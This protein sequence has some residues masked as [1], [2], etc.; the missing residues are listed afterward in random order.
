MNKRKF[1][2][3]AALAFVLHGCATKPQPPVELKLSE[4]VS[5]TTRV[6]VAAPAL[7]KV[8]TFFPGA[9]CLLCIALAEGNHS[10]LTK[11]TQTLPPEG[12]DQLKEEIAQLLREQGATVT[13]VQEPLD[14]RKLPKASRKSEQTARLDFSSMKK[15][16]VDKLVVVNISALGMMRNYSAYVPNGV[17]RAILTGEG[18][19]VN[20]ADNTY[21][22]YKPID[23]GREAEG[24][25]DEPPSFPG[26]T[27]A[28]FQVLTEGRDAILEPFRPR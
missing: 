15:L 22:W 3:L 12:L 6:A 16:D 27:N 23:I 21:E 10:A 9:G 1:L 14:L 25:W 28:Y 24:G 8:N 18:Y 4:S 5:P 11:H 13:V 7:P 17:P 20:L 19:M 2:V 26:L